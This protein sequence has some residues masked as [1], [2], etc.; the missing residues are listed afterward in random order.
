MTELTLDRS[1]DQAVQIIKENSKSF[2]KAFK[3]LEREKFLGVAGLYAFFRTIDDLADDSTEENKEESLNRLQD[4]ESD[5]LKIYKNER[6]NSSYS[7]WPAFET[8][9]KKYE[10]DPKGF[11][12]QLEGQRSD[13]NF[14]DIEDEKELIEYSKNVAGSVGRTILPIIAFKNKDD[15][16]LLKACENL[17]IGMQITNILRDVGEDLRL[18]D[19]MY[20]PKSLLSEYGLS[21]EK[22][23]LFLKEDFNKEDFTAFKKVWERLA[24]L[25]ESYYDS[26]KEYLP[27]IDEDSRLSVYASSLIYRAILDQIRQ[28]NY[29]CL[30]KKQ[31]VSNAKKLSLIKKAKET[32]KIFKEN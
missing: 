7:W 29:D 12:M 9:I 13:I 11:L 5:L 2:Y 26:F 31:A 18:R 1:F 19:R 14:E 10:I 15:E 22:I 25:S 27:M 28:S 4:L 6:V 17:G 32:V 3:M 30:T 20:L 16:D 21:K 23:R 24:Q 8:T